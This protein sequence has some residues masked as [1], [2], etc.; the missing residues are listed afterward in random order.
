MNT[1]PEFYIPESREFVV[2]DEWPF[3][4]AVS[5]YTAGATLTAPTA[6]VYRRS[7]GADVTAT[8]WPGGAGTVTVTQVQWSAF[9]MLAAG[10]YEIR[11][12][13]DVSGNTRTDVLRVR[14]YS[15]A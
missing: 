14:V 3:Q 9:K 6:K 2:S 5:K 12:S 1:E 10:D 15:T 7:D 8:W 13:V 4:I 11:L